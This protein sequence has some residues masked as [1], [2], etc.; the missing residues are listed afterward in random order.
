MSKPWLEPPYGLR[1]PGRMAARIVSQPEQ[2][3]EAEMSATRALK[4]LG[5]TELAAI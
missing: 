3:E 2:I 4:D 1:D 5:L